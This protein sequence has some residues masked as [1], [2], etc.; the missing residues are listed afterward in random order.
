MSIANLENTN[1]N[2]NTT[3]S[4]TCNTFN[5]SGLVD[6]NNVECSTI[7]FTDPLVSP[8]VQVPM[9]KYS[10]GFVP[11]TYSGA[12]LSS[13]LSTIVNFEMFGNRVTLFF[14]DTTFSLTPDASSY[15]ESTVIHPGLVPSAKSST[16]MAGL[17][18]PSATQNKNLSYSILAN[19]KIRITQNI[20]ELIAQTMLG[21]TTL[22][23]PSC[24]LTYYLT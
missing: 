19:G 5:V 14:L 23:I 13:P 22:F 17:Y 4:I 24:S 11:I 2:I 7:T 20:D 1:I 6:L 18:S 12:V 3:G 21:Q 16:L 9:N 15:I 8:L 10:R